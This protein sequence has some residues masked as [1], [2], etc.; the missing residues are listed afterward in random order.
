MMERFEDTVWVNGVTFNVNGLY[1]KGRSAPYAY[2][3][4]DPSF[5]D[6]GDSTEIEE[7]SIY[8]GA[9]EVS[10]VITDG[11]KS[12]IYEELLEKLD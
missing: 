3:H 2:S 5:S 8:I 7:I 1:T 9:Q 12:K 4:D 11:V 10:E 6:P